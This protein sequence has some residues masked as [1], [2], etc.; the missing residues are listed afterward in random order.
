MQQDGRIA[1]LDA[2]LPPGP[3]PKAAAFAVRTRD[4]STDGFGSKSGLSNSPLLPSGTAG[5]GTS[6]EPSVAAVVGGSVKGV[7]GGDVSG[8][9]TP[10]VPERPSPGSS[11]TTKISKKRKK[12]EEAAHKSERA[13]P[14]PSR[15]KSSPSPSRSVVAARNFFS[16]PGAGHLAAGAAALQ[17]HQQAQESAESQ[18]EVVGES[19]K[20]ELAKQAEENRT[21]RRVNESLQASERSARAEA[22]KRDRELLELKPRLADARE[23]MEAMLLEAARREKLEKEQLLQRECHEIGNITA[24]RISHA[25]SEVWEEGAAFRSLELRRKQAASERKSVEDRM[26]QVKAQRKKANAAAK[27]AAKAEA[28]GGGSNSRTSSP[29][30]MAPPAQPTFS[31][32]AVHDLNEEVEICTMRLKECK[33]KEA[34]LDTEQVMIHRTAASPRASH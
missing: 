31:P 26:K 16:P 27:N 14:S 6:A 15:Q 22:E 4:N 23:A 7:G 11:P 28:G 34:L 9:V 13:A 29:G 18:R 8:M 2:R 20:D 5:A 3:P 32:H 21:L 30:V 25:V 12:Q 19:V 1:L 17:A 10:Q 24:Q 33:E